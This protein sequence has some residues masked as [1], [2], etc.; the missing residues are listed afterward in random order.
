MT[1][2]FQTAIA[3][4]T[5]F[6]FQ[7]EIVY[8]GPIRSA[9]WQLISTPQANVIGAT[10]FTITSGALGIQGANCGTAAAGGSGN[11]AGIL[12][13]PKVYTNFGNITTATMTL[14]DD[15]VAELVTMGQMLVK[16]TSAANPGDLVVYDNTTGALSSV[17]Q[18]VA[19]TAS[20][21]TNVMTVTVAPTAGSLGVGSLINAAGVAPGTYII[22]GSGPY[23]LSTS[24]GTVAA[25]AATATGF[26]GSGKTFVPRCKTILRPSAANALAMIELT[27]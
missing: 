22:S 7:G 23:T 13:N 6:G 17:P 9:P 19:F 27:N 18:M 5:V 1:A 11:F 10:A 2:P 12:A 3:F 24:P 20:F 4:Q 15:T 26:A 21:A 25:E 16:L 14:P 8:D